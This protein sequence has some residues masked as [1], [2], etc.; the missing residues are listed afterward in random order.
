MIDII[1]Y[2]FSLLFIWSN[3]YYIINYNRLDKRFAE[4]D[5]NSKVDLVYYVT[6]VLFWIWLVVGLFTPMKY[7]FMI[8]MGIGL[9]RIPMYHI[10]KNLTS[11]WFRL[12]PVFYTILMIQ[13]LIEIFKH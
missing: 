8:M 9:I 6:K 4:R 13:I 1:I 10:S 12:T 5:R 11:V 2:T 7:I 3:I